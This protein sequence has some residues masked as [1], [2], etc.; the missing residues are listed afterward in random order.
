M[1]VT[2]WLFIGACTAAALAAVL[3]PVL[4]ALKYRARNGMVYVRPAGRHAWHSQYCLVARYRKAAEQ[5]GDPDGFP[6]CICLWRRPDP[7]V[8]PVDSGLGMMQ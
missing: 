3:S 7:P 8:G 4:K 1:E 5:G 2:D 6:W